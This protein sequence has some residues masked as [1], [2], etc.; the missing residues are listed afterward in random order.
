MNVRHNYGYLCYTM[1]DGNGFGKMQVLSRLPF[2]FPAFVVQT[3]SL[4]YE[5][6]LSSRYPYSPLLPRSSLRW[7]LRGCIA[8]LAE[9]WSAC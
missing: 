2:D 1:D 6:F 3:V 9:R 7:P 5:D 4:P 8:L